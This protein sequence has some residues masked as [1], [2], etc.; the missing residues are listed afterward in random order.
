MKSTAA[1]YLL[2]LG[3]LAVLGVIATGTLNYLADPYGIYHYG[4]PSDWVKSRP[5]IRNLERLHKAYAVR[6]AQA[7][8]LLLGNSRVLTGLAPTHP[9]LLPP[10]YNLALSAANIYECRRYLEH[11]AAFHQPKLVLLGI[12]QWMF[13]ADSQPEADFT[14]ERL[15]VDVALRPQRP[16][17]P[18]DLMASLFSTSAVRDSLLTLAG[19]AKQVR[20]PQG[21][22]DESLM[23]PYLKAPQV[24]AEN[25][26]WIKD[27][28]TKPFDLFEP[29]GG[30]LQFDA[31]AGIV[32]FC[33]ERGIR[34]CIF[35][36]PLHAE[37]LDY[38]LADGHTYRQWMTALLAC[39]ETNSTGA[40][41]PPEV[42]D[43]CGF[44]PVTTEPFPEPGETE[45]RMRYY[46]E[47]SHFR[48]EVGDMM[49]AAMLAGENNHLGNRVTSATLEAEW[50]KLEEEHRRWKSRVGSQNASAPQP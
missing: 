49:L 26:R 46:W 27:M 34:L 21:M 25:A 32:H 41:T 28:R 11:A 5:R 33:A 1:K 44:N 18:P 40:A 35:T 14:E 16:W 2:W 6:T 10:A 37:T 22:R 30:N 42:W 19:R 3:V 45:S 7:E 43:F 31:L 17:L 29:D 38:A 36:N 23:R 48:K 15:A 50:T 13:D 8:T 39:V 4:E 24:L 47:I 9:A 20:Y 12:D